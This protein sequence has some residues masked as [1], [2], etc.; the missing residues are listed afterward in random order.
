MQGEMDICIYQG[1]SNMSSVVYLNLTKCCKLIFQLQI[2]ILT[3][4]LNCNLEDVLLFDL[5]SFYRDGKEW[6]LQVKDS[7]LGRKANSQQNP[8][9]PL[10]L[11]C[12]GSS[13]I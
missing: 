3:A 2:V 10:W 1:Q 12:D 5:N 6:G 13:L 9:R 7:Y 11:Q 8:L 4:I